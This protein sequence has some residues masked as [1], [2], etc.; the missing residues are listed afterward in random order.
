MEY[1]AIKLLS[2]ISALMFILVLVLVFL[3]IYE[4]FVKHRE[5]KVEVKIQRVDKNL[6]F[7]VPKKGSE[8]AAGFDMYAVDVDGNKY[9]NPCTGEVVIRPGETVKF[10]TNVRLVIPSGYYLDI[11]PRSG[12]SIC[13]GIGVINSPARIDS[14]YRGEIII[15]I[16]NYS[17]FDHSVILGERVAQCT[18]H[19]IIPT[20]FVRIP[21]S[22]KLDKTER[23]EGRFGHSGRV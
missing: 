4:L 15:G 7:Y 14:D 1:I 8:Y 3:Y 2:G 10:K 9:V 6:A 17:N 22:K 13:H 21:T 5:R 16:H 19:K 11:C 20:E 18:L 12:L 23:G